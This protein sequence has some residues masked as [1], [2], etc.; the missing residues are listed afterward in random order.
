MNEPSQ[1]PKTGWRSL[2]PVLL[3]WLGSLFV[4]SRV[5]A[6]FMPLLIEQHLHL[7]LVALSPR[8]TLM[9]LA[10]PFVDPLPLVT[11]MAARRTLA[12]AMGYYAGRHFGD[13]ALAWMETRYARIARFLRRVERL[14]TKASVPTLFL[15]PGFITSLLSGT[16]PMPVTRY[17]VVAF[18][19]SVTWAALVLQLAEPL[20]PLLLWLTAF[21]SEH[22]VPLTVASVVIVVGYELHRRRRNLRALA[23]ATAQTTE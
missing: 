23:A 10:A 5:G 14:F 18:A 1:P 19:G 7:L 21:M 3:V 17:V 9:L 20:T 12:I 8:F 22:V 16:L 4:L 15:W 2:P 13:G 11:V 6:M